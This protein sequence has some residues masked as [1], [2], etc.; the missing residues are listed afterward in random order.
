M[1]ERV[2]RWLGEK[3]KTTLTKLKQS[4][5][6]KIITAPQDICGAVW[7]FDQIINL[8]K[9]IEAAGLTWAIADGLIINESIKYGGNNI[10]KLISDV[11]ESLANVGEAGINTVCYSFQKEERSKST[12]PQSDIEENIK[13]FVSQLIPVCEEYNIHISFY[14]ENYS[15]NE[16]ISLL[17]S[18]DSLYNG[19]T[20][21]INT[22]TQGSALNSELIK[23]YSSRIQLINVNCPKPYSLYSKSFSLNQIEEIISSIFNIN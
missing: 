13:Y 15:E 16:G 21:N 11:I 12:L 7:N 5:L 19:I 1:M 20:L 6:K 8:K 22:K 14:S 9:E 17:N 3:D 10:D 2:G 23:R 4:G 18:V